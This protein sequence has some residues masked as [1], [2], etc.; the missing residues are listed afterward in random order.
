MAIS[1]QHLSDG[2][3]SLEFGTGDAEAVRAAIAARYGKMRRRRFVLAAEVTI[4]GERFAFQNQWNDP[5]LISRSQRG[6]EMLERIAND[7]GA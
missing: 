6:A 4:G 1:L 3:A 7:L 5:C 2:A